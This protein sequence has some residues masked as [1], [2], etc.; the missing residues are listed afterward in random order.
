MHRV[1]GVLG[2][3]RTPWR[4]LRCW[5]LPSLVRRNRAAK[6]Q[7]KREPDSSPRC[8]V[9][10]LSNDRFENQEVDDMTANSS[11]DFQGIADRVEIEALRAEF[12]DAVMMR[13]YDRLA[14]LFTAGGAL[15]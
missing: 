5:Q 12:T 10:E 7:A 6:R 13:D 4:R 8:L 14:S 15:R 11:G 9:E 1:R 2:G 3:F